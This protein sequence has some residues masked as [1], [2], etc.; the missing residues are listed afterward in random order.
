MCYLVKA[1]HLNG[2][3]WRVFRYWL[4]NFRTTNMYQHFRKYTRPNRCVSALLF[5]CGRLHL[6]GKWNARQIN[7][8]SRVTAYYSANEKMSRAIAVSPE[9]PRREEKKK[10]YCSAKWPKCCYCVQVFLVPIILRVVAAVPL[11]IL[12]SNVDIF[13]I[14]RLFVSSEIHIS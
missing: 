7:I 6:E 12:Q 8:N 9:K 5:L 3:E 10:N 13:D 14:F 2:N 4:H 11:T 1:R